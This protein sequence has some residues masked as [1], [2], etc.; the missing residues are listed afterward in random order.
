MIEMVY[1]SKE[2]EEQGN[3]TIPKNIRQIGENNS[4]QKIYVEDNVITNLKKRTGKQEDVN[5]G[6]LL[7]EIKRKNGNTY[8]FVKGMV[9][10][11]E[12]IENSLIFNDDIW[13]AIYKDIKKYFS[14]MNIV[15]WFVSVPYRVRDDLKGIRKLH[16]DNFAGNDKVCFLTDRTE[17]D[18]NFYMCKQ[19]NLEKQ[20]GYYIYYE[21]NEKM[22]KYIKS[23]NNEKNESN[24]NNVAKENSK[25][26]TSKQKATNDNL[27]NNDLK[28]NLAGN[29]SHNSSQNANQNSIQNSTRKN[30]NLID[31]NKNKLGTKGG[32]LAATFK[33]QRNNMRAGGTNQHKT[34]KGSEHVEIKE[35]D[36][37]R[38][39]S[40]REILKE[41]SGNRKQG[42]VA[43]G[44]SSL[45]IIALLLSTVVMLN[46]Y[47]ELKNIKQT[48]SGYSMNEEARAVNQQLNSNSEETKEILE[49]SK[50]KSKSATNSNLDKN[51]KVSEKDGVQ[52]DG[53]SKDM[54]DENDNQ[55][56]INQKSKNQGDSSQTGTQK[57]EIQ[58]NSSQNSS[59]KNNSEQNFNELENEN[60]NSS[61]KKEANAANDSSK[62][63]KKVN[64]V[65]G[66][67]YT[68]KKGQTL[69][70]ISMKVYGTS[71][72]VDEIKEYNDIDDD[73]TIIEGQK[74]LLP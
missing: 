45:L 46:N 12:V 59:S 64:N 67:S 19:G 34:I 53:V 60:A 33:N 31:Q 24:E 18:E 57:N 28:K 49:D 22:K 2:S 40:F 15:G 29:S 73:Y 55:E 69:Y 43:Y 11:R 65:A 42:R 36:I 38:P 9:E 32:K 70:D 47:G 63:T 13:A 6:V 16:L 5:Y 48:L 20:S 3:V 72:M 62:K 37:N 14:K 26:V 44:I 10:V 50:D 56:N 68:V 52:S 74:I 51:N 30:E 4:N 1:S 7:G 71:K 35:R 54:Q 21:R 58:N 17:N 23:L 39:K 61:V 66:M 27:V 25:G 41:E 8:V